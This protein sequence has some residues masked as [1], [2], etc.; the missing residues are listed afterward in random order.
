MQET[1]TI[2][3]VTG[4]IS[5]LVIAASDS[6]I[7][8]NEICHIKIGE[9]NLLGEVIKV[10]EKDIFVQCFESTRGLKVGSEVEF[11]GK[12]LEVKLGP[13]MLS[14]TYDGLQNDLNKLDSL[15]LMR[16]Q[17]NDALD[18]DSKWEFTPTAKVGET[19]KSGDWL[20]EVIENTLTHKIMVPFKAEGVYII[21]N[22]VAKGE[23]GLE[24]N[25]VTIGNNDGEE[26]N[27]TMVQYW[28]IK[29]AIKAYSEKV[30]PFSMLETGVRIMDS[31]NPL[32]E[33]GTGFIPGAFGTGKTVLQ[34]AISKQAA[35]DVVIFAACGERANEIVEVFTEFPK[36]VDPH[37]GKKLM[38]RTIIIAN[39]S[40][41]PVAAREA[42]VYTAMTLAEYY[43]TMGLKVLIL[44][45]STSRWAQA[46]REI[47]NR[48]EELPGPD[49]FPMDLTAVIAAFYARAGFTYLN[50]GESGSIT[51][52]GTVSPSGGNLKEPVTEATKKTARC[53]Y[54]LSQKRADQKRYPAV[55][56]VSSY[57]KYLEY[58]E[59]VD[60]LHEHVSPLWV[61]NISKTK[62]ILIRSNEIKDQINILGDDGV[63]LAYHLA[64]WKAELIDF[65]ILQQDAFDK[66]DAMTP[67]DRQRFMLELVLKVHTMEFKLEGF[68]AL[69]AYFKR[70]INQLKQLNYTEYESDEFKEILHEFEA[71][72]KEKRIL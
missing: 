66:I 50:N 33:G 46:L 10:D 5:N 37:T 70:I 29:R 65:V 38:E 3:Q 17:Y 13:G 36:L 45:D 39:T 71:I 63:P 72:I 15:F 41:M 1:K 48:L 64:F 11:A 61:E 56:P 42:S 44:A 21:K 4:V 2:G 67:M 25:L 30:R 28:P 23:Y 58:P 60:Y 55:D 32:M 43:R 22:I 14:K 62:D 6:P 47:S 69:A 35:A 68:E 53:F 12:M 19:V 18:A 27:V 9:E 34:H 24:D 16:G 57:S 31:L 51:F 40:N 26:L 20:G 59:V 7:A 52:L 49:A 8:Q 54:A